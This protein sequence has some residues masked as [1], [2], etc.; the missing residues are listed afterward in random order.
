MPRPTDKDSLL[1]L[2][3]QRYQQLISTI[4]QL[5]PAQQHTDFP[6]GTLNRNIRDVLAH[7]HHWHLLMLKWYEEGM[8]GKKPE[9]PAPGYSWKTVPAL[10]QWINTNYQEQSLADIRVELQKSHEDVL[11][12]IVPHTD[13]ELFTK[14]YYNWTGST[15]LGAY[16]I[17]ATSSHYDW[18]RKLIRKVTRT[19]PKR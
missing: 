6:E 19:Q 4:D 16:L 2:A 8:A 11:A 10:N 15:S 9:M 3:Q 7:L 14:K 5:T 1:Q 18:A 12:L 17:S 13:T